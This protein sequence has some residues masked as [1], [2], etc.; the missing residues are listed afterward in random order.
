VRFTVLI[1]TFDNGPVV[2]GAIESALQQTLP[3]VEVFVVCDGAP[4]ETLDAVRA[5]A[6]QDARVRCFEH[7][8]GERHGEAWRHLALVEATG[9]AVC[10]LGDDDWWFPDH[11]ETMSALLAEADFAHTR[12][13]QLDPDYRIWAPTASLADHTVRQR[14]RLEA[15]NCF[16]PTAAGHRLDA[17]RR[18]DV[19]WAPGP[20]E[21]WSDLNMWRKWLTASGVRFAASPLAT[22]LKLSRAHR[23]NQEVDASRWE[24]A[25]WRRAFSDP[26]LREALRAVLSGD[27]DYFP[28]LLVEERA[29][30]LRAEGLAQIHASLAQL[31]EAD[32]QARGELT[33]VLGSRTWRYAQPLRRMW[34]GLRDALRLDA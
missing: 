6:A 18:L 8:K 29:Q 24:L 2:S 13:V 22:T 3:P 1:P 5:I 4:A 12:H 10:Y 31:R 32:A 30:Q 27:E 7:G 14:M 25:F 26:A 34:R 16:G 19:G 28:M 23:P 11:L 17:Y 33:R 21:V 9:D 15:F 20:A